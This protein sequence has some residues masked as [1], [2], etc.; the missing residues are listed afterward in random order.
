MLT[1]L[2]A[3][4]QA[5]SSSRIEPPTFP[6]LDFSLSG[7]LLTYSTERLGQ[8]HNGQRSEVNLWLCFCDYMCISVGTTDKKKKE[9]KKSTWYC[10]KWQQSVSN[11]NF[12]C[13]D[14][15]GEKNLCSCSNEFQTVP[16]SWQ[17]GSQGCCFL[18]QVLAGTGLDIRF[19]FLSP[20]GDPLALDLYRSDGIH[21]WV[22]TLKGELSQ[23][24]DFTHLRVWWHFL[25]HHFHPIHDNVAKDSNIKNKTTTAD[26]KT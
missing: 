25:I 12:L 9:R 21:M 15:L 8:T 3:P 6:A 1:T 4:L 13:T 22:V 2:G 14:L 5:N 26:E 11:T 19:T 10:S 7:N 17:N 16:A 24:W 18:L 20:R 23:N